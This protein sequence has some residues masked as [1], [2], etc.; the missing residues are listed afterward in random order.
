MDQSHLNSSS[1][2]TLEIERFALADELSQTS[3]DAYLTFALRHVNTFTFDLF[4][5]QQIGPRERKQT[6]VRR[7]W[8]M[9]FILKQLLKIEMLSYF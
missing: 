3:V 9:V 4:G 7:Y 1:L 6:R 8:R 2:I 5:W